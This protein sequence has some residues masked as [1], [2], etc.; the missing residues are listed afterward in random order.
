MAST[1]TEVAKAMAVCMET[2]GQVTPAEAM[3]LLDFIQC[4]TATAASM[5]TTIQD[6][7]DELIEARNESNILFH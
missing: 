4:L 7:E 5:Q 1:S 6:L 2:K 3:A